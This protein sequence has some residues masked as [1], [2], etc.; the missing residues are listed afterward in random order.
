VNIRRLENITSVLLSLVVLILLIVRA[1]H[2][3]ALWRDECGALQLATM[4]TFADVARNYQHEAFPLPFSATLRVFTDIFGASD[5][6]LRAF[7]LLVGIALIGIAWF[8]ARTIDGGGPLLLLPLVGLNANFLI[9]GT[10]VRG[11]GIG[12]VLLLFTLGLAVK[13]FRQ[14]SRLNLVCAL[15][16]SIASVQFLLGNL[17]LIGA[18]TLSASLVLI[19]RRRF[20]HALIVCAL[21]AICAVSFAPYLKT[22]LTADWN[23]ILKYPVSF[24]SLAAKFAQALAESGVWAAWFVGIAVVFFF[25]A[26][27]WRLRFL[28]RKNSMDADTLIFLLTFLV[29]A[30]AAYYGFL[31]MLSYP[32]QSW[33]YLPLF[34]AVAGSID[35]ISAMLS[36]AAWMRVARLLFAIAGL[37]FLPFV[38]WP[39]VTQRATNIDMVA[40]SLEQKVAAGDLIV[41]NHWHF[42]ISFYR[43]YHGE[44]PWITVPVISEHRIHRYDLLK[45]K[46]LESDP[47]VDVRSRI[48][49][50][51]ESGNRVWIVG[52]ARPPEPGLPLSL[53]PAPD[54]IFGWSAPAYANVWSMQLAAFL[55]AHTEG[56]VVLGRAGDVNTNE[57]VPLLVARGWRD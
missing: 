52:G 29:I 45:A 3:G 2:A 34:C 56:E 23:I 21:G 10:A 43:Y 12:A 4:P 26:A 19:F 28:W 27:C 7:G 38:V 30:I 48:Q 41:V 32:T 49:Q 20:K 42:G 51:L 11:Y 18:M 15:V 57:N 47:L 9:W 14:P 17:P 25:V 8:N 5:A 24:A 13:A 16:A 54:P 44:A 40:R 50:T 36:R 1:T 53:Q 35:L 39:G 46:M 33:Y 37:L 6:S 55:A 31:K 22:Y